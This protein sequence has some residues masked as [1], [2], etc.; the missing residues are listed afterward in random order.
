MSLARRTA[1]AGHAALLEQP[2]MDKA[3]ANLP[4]LNRSHAG[5]ER[6]D[7]ALGGRVQ[8][9]K[10]HFGK[11]RDHGRVKPLLQNTQVAVQ[12]V[13]RRMLSRAHLCGELP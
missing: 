10:L 7:L 11:V 4:Q 5:P 9:Q 2:L 6:C 13:Q 3:L 1:Q 12:F 8:S